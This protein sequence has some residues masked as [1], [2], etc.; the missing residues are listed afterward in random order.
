[1]K[2]S[3]LC[4]VYLFSAFAA[5][6]ASTLDF[7][8]YGNPTTGPFGSLVGPISYTDTQAPTSDGYLAGNTLP[9][10]SNATRTGT[11]SFTTLGGTFG[12]TATVAD[13]P[14][15]A[16]DGGAVSGGFWG[17]QQHPVLPSPAFIVA[18][19]T[20]VAVAQTQIN[21]SLQYLAPTGLN[22]LAF[23]GDGDTL[24]TMGFDFSTLVGGVLP[25]GSWIGYADVDGGERAFLNAF[26]A[27]NVALAN[28]WTVMGYGDITANAQTSNQNDPVLA[29]YPDL[30]T[31]TSTELRILAGNFANTDSVITFLQTTADIRSLD[32]SAF[33]TDLSTF[34]QSVAIAPVPEPASLGLALLGVLPLLR[35]CRKE[36]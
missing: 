23:K 2:I 30:S 25:A 32:I 24:V 3:P 7:A 12:I 27:G 1:M 26:D 13:D 36:S 14:T 19:P 21:P 17:S 22:V 5:S 28:W 20:T 10:G 29:D 33:D 11:G 18:R 31:S 4:S 9:A 16:G 8:T 15:L 34:Y 6:A 35:R